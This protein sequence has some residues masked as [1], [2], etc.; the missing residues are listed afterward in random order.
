MQWCNL[1][2]F[3]A[4]PAARRLGVTRRTRCEKAKG[5]RTQFPVASSIVMSSFFSPSS[6]SLCS[7][8]QHFLPSFQGSARSLSTKYYVRAAQFLHA[9]FCARGPLSSYPSCCQL[10]G[11]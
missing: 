3:V 4:A 9:I 10:A 8:I 7:S 2:Y 1:W 5:R 6:A 11:A